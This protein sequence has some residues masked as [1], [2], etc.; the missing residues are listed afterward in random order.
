MLFR[1]VWI[2]KNQCFENIPS[3]TWEFGIGGYQPAQK[4]LKER[5]GRTLSYED[6]DHYCRICGAL[7]ETAAIMKR[8]DTAIE[9]HGGWPLH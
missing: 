2:N 6:I 5:K 4:W 1:S 9:K 3:Q 7:Q 8:I